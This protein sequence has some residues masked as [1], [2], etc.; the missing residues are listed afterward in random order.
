MA[1][2]KTHKTG[3]EG[4]SKTISERKARAAKMGRNTTKSGRIK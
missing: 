4:K 2:H 3:V 1:A